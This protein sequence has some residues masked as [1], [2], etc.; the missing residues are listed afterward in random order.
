MPSSYGFPG[1]FLSRGQ[2]KAELS[3]MKYYPE[4]RCS[5]A[6]RCCF[7]W[8]DLHSKLIRAHNKGRELVLYLVVHL[9]DII[10]LKKLR[11]IYNHLW[12]SHC[13]LLHANNKTIHFVLKFNRYFIINYD[14]SIIVSML[15]YIFNVFKNQILFYNVLSADRN[16]NWI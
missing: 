11:F 4:R 12:M 16:V 8:L 5:R 14:L 3:T 15:L 9:V 7:E 10:F 1:R 6:V 2:Q 13:N